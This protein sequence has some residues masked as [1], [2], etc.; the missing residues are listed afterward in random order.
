MDIVKQNN[1]LTNVVK[2]LEKI[3]GLESMTILCM[4]IDYVANR[5][6]MKSIELL[7]IITPLIERVNEDMGQWN[8]KE[9][10]EAKTA[11]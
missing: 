10:T 9:I 7:D 6:G 4:L 8:Y 1:V 11:E 2:E 3:S 5:N